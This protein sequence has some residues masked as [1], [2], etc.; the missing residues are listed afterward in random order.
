MKR[1]RAERKSTK[2]SLDAKRSNLTTEQAHRIRCQPPLIMNAVEG[3]AYTDTSERN[4][5]KLAAEGVFP[6]FRI[7][8]R[9]LWRLDALDAAIATLGQK[10][11]N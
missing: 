8:R 5:R 6:N 10:K 11:A 2:A 1:Q 9:V 4:F 3:A 7:G